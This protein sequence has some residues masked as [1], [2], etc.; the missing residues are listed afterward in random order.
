MRK[1]LVAWGLMVAGAVV[2]TAAQFDMAAI[3]KW[4][5]AKVV[6]YAV[7]GVFRAATPLAGESGGTIYALVEAS[8]RVTIDFDFDMKTN[9]I[10]GKPVFTNAPSQ[11][12][13]ANSG[14]AECSP[15]AVKGPYEHFELAAIEPGRDTLTLKGTRSFPDAGVSADWPATC[16][17]RMYPAK[18]TEVSEVIAVTSPML[19]LMPS[20]ANPNL[21]VSAD[22]KSFTLKNQGWSWT[23][24]PT[25]VK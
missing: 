25:I 1:L 18:K 16:K 24:T 5:A 17:Q 11:V 3:Q 21:V 14:K 22:K 2:N 15:P 8:D 13:S 10:V 20:G 23:Y 19:L 9:A 4:Q 6:H 12:I 7:V